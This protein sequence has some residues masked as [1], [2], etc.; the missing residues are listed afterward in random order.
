M[1]VVD[2]GDGPGTAALVDELGMHAST[3][4]QHGPSG[5][6]GARNSGIAAALGDWIAFLDD[7]DL[8]AP[9]KAASAADR[10]RERRAPGWVYAGDV[11][12][13]EGLCVR[14]W[15]PPPPPDR[16]SPGS[17]ATM[18]YP[19][20]HR[21][22]WCARDVLEPVGELRPC[23]PH[24]RGLG[25]VASPRSDRHPRLRATPARRAADARAMAS[26]TVDRMLAD[27]EVI[28][29]AMAFPWTGRA[30]SGGQHGCAWRMVTVGRRCATTAVRP[31]AGD[32]ACRRPRGG[33]AGHRTWQSPNRSGST[34]GPREAQAWLETGPVARGCHDRTRTG[35]AIEAAARDRRD[36]PRIDGANAHRPRRPWPPRSWRSS[37]IACPWSGV[38]RRSQ[39]TS[40][41]ASRPS[42][43]GLGGFMATSWRPAGRHR[44][45]RFLEILLAAAVCGSALRRRDCRV[46]RC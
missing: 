17:V 14:G 12:V 36:E 13:D 21:T 9:G 30:I 24:E 42:S 38:A 32:I 8:W 39:T 37:A 46:A 3:A 19:R 41:I 35:P 43:S 28:A 2:D 45:A 15:A 31:L 10:G 11:T 33:G 18:P 26:R 44:P 25:S 20:A 6:S 34:T 16:S 29:A 4:A 40:T 22:S 7:D 5:V 1:L 23:A 27:I